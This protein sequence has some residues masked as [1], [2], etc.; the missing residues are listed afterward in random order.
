MSASHMHNRPLRTE[1]HVTHAARRTGGKAERYVGLLI[2][3][4]TSAEPVLFFKGFL[5]LAVRLAPFC[6][7]VAFFLGGCVFASP[8]R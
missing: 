4:S 7:A 3:L 2:A 5:D 8:L 6:L 1:C